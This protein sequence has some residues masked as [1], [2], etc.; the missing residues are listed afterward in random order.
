MVMMTTEQ[1]E[2]IIG[3]EELSMVLFAIIITLLLQAYLISIDFPV[4]LW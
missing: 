1:K 3:N 4:R 2:N